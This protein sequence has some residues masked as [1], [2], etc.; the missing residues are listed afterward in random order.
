M[1]MTGVDRTKIKMNR[2]QKGVEGK[3]RKRME[4]AGR[5]G[6]NEEDYRLQLRYT[7]E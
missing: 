7:G 5:E 3:S 6:K 1:G 4:A 2:V